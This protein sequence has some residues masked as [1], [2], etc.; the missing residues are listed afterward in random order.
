MPAAIPYLASAAATALGA[1]A[2]VASVVTV[3]TSLLVA[4]YQRDKL[5]RRQRGAA[6]AEARNRTV[7]VRSGVAP[8]K[9]VLGTARVSGPLMYAEFVGPDEEYFDSIVALTHGEISELVGVYADDEYIPA[10]AISATVPTSGKYSAGAANADRRTETHTI[11]ASATVTLDHPPSELDTIFPVLTSGEGDSLSQL[12]LVVSTVVGNVLT[13]SAPV[14]GDVVVS[15]TTRATVDG[16]LRLQWTTGTSTQ[17]STSWAGVSTPK[18]TTDHRLRGVSYLRALMRMEDNVYATGTPNLS[19][20]VRGP[21]GVYDPRTDTTVNYTSNPALLAAWFR[22]L[23]RADGGM[24]VP[25]TWIDWPSVATAANVC[26]ELISVKKLDGSGYENVKRYECHTV[27]TL[28]QAPAD[29]LRVIL[30]AMA[31][32]FPFTG[33]KY[34]CF[35]GAFRAAA[36]TL[37][38][39]D[40]A[41]DAAITV[42]PLSGGDQVPPNT[43]SAT[44]WN[45]ATGWT[46]TGAR[47]VS[48]AT[49]IAEDGA[50]EVLA[51][52]LPATTD[53]RQANYLMG[54]QLEQARPGLSAA[55]SVNGRGANI[56]L[57]DTLQLNLSGYSALA[58]RT[59]EVRRRSNDWR[60]RYPLELREVRAT[61]YALAADRFTP[62]APVTKPD[63]SALFRPTPVELTAVTNDALLQSDGTY[64][65]RA[66]VTWTAHPQSFVRDGGF[67]ELRWQRPGAEW[68]QVPPVPG[69]AV[70]AYL[71]PLDDGAIIYIEA[72]ARNGL[73]AVSEWTGIAPH[74]VQGKLAP[75]ANVTG[76]AFEI[77]AGGLRLSW[78]PC[79]DIDYA[80]TV[81]KHGATWAGAAQF[82]QGKSSDFTVRPPGDGTYVVWA[83]HVDTSGNLS[84]T[85]AS[86][87]VD[88]VGLG[89]GADAQTL[90]LKATGMA[91]I[92]ESG[93]S[94]STSPTITFTAALQNITG[95]A[96]FVATAKDAAGATLGTITLGGSGNVR[97][98][99]PAQFTNAG[100]WAT[101]TVEVSATLGTLSDT[102]TVFRG[103]N[104]SSVVQAI[105]SN[106]SHTLP[107]DAAGTVSSYAGSGTNIRVFEGINELDYD[108]VGTAAGKWTVS[109]SATSITRGTLTESGLQLNVGDHS[110]MT[111]DKASISYTISGKRANGS[112]FS[113]V[114]L[115][116]LSKSK[117]GTAGAGGTS[118]YTLEIYS[119]GLSSTPTSS[120]AT[121]TFST[122]T[123]TPGN[124]TAG[125]SRTKPAPT[126]GAP[127]YRSA[128]T[129]TTTTPGTPVTAGTWST[130]VIDSQVGG[131]GATGQSNHRVYIAASYSTPPATPSPTTS[132]ATPA[133]WSATPVSL[134]T[135]QAQWQSDGTTPAGS[136]TTTWAAPYQSY[137][138]FASLDAISANMGTIT[139]GN[140]T[141]TG[142]L[143]ADG[144]SSITLYD[145][146]AAVNNARTVAI[147][148]NVSG[149]S[150][151]GVVGISAAANIPA[152]YGYNSNTLGYGVIGFGKVGTYGASTQV[153]G[154]GAYGQST[155][156]DGMG[157][158]GFAPGTGGIGVYAQAQGAGRYGAVF[159]TTG[160]GSSA[161]EV[162]L[163]LEVGHAN[164]IGLECDAQ[165]TFSQRITSTLSGL[166]V[167]LV[168]PRVSSKPTAIAGGV[169][170]HTSY[171]LIVSDGTNWY[172]SSL[173]T[174]P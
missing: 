13:L 116:N 87:T 162:A 121:Y 83:V 158:F 117:T 79:T 131:A 119:A 1:S 150:Q 8:R 92:F 60:G 9:L 93:A 141:T 124:L 51:L 118:T 22:T 94:T 56:G 136:T 165:A 174:V 140:I 27:L 73:G 71:A 95:T 47:E 113:F 18:W 28:D 2:F 65:N 21:K 142:Y 3:A 134:T 170:L 100:T 57:M 146:L 45:A 29:N 40:V 172:Y 5:R 12:V 67:I 25:S 14:T 26:D 34:R 149:A 53:E 166:S 126:A 125:W 82:W 81:L 33:S 120:T 98:L 151:I 23:P 6:A 89:E 107:A 30:D 122:D 103:D 16:P 58:G 167:P 128:Y 61:T 39:A 173:L 99:T 144:N 11:T 164:N 160:I 44:F 143:R 96:T 135:G 54:V 102:V 168:L 156:T 157:V 77:V 85:P 41:A 129:F 127:V 138:K 24:G 159:G 80:S 91:F 154:I 123:F 109:T 37:T 97:T 147:A 130:P 139:S 32:E 38:D 70:Q 161:T 17:A 101:Q 36:L 19:A 7:T 132:G 88:Y 69:S 43:A 86:I 62:A 152:V 10:S 137:A 76:L 108:G 49:Y 114:R 111:A 78:N 153:G 133:G 110:A 115:Q 50:E 46:E 171:G 59:F 106:E 20:V 155:N 66:L 105:F 15:Y 64:I 104:G 72:R 75:P 42:A 4:G 68:V 31:G 63:N 163:R 55:L 169:A 112:A 148:G 90:D 52:D 145:P 48:N 74:T 35:A 84:A